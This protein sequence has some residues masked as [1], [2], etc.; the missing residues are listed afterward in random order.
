MKQ[1]VSLQVLW[2]SRFCSATKTGSSPQH[3]QQPLTAHLQTS[4]HQVCIGDQQEQAAQ[5]PFAQGCYLSVTLKIWLFST[6]VPRQCESFCLLR[7]LQ[8]KQNTVFWPPK[9]S[10]RY[11]SLRDKTSNHLING[12]PPACSILTLQIKK[13]KLLSANFLTNSWF[14]PQPPDCPNSSQVD[15]TRTTEDI[16]PD[17]HWHIWP[18]TILPC[19]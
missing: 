9:Q 15:C 12:S 18:M 5:L 13:K 11:P 14:L 1:E 17:I 19:W 2:P 8:C 16:F 7:I 6:Q 4:I 3:I 10:P